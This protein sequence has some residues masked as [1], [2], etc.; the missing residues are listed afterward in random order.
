MKTHKVNLVG[1]IDDNGKL[2]ISNMDELRKF[3]K[4]WRGESVI[5]VAQVNPESSSKALQ[6]YYFNKIVPDYQQIF[7]DIGY[8]ISL[9]EVDIRLRSMS[10]IMMVEIPKEESGGFALERIKTIYELSSSEMVEYIDQLRI[11]AS[12]EHHYNIVDPKSF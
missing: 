12:L 2:L 8:A 11:I 3:S 1:K 9:H 7:R 5:M 10:A 6:G 4:K